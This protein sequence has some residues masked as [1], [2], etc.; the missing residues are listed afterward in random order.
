MQFLA[1]L[2]SC[3]ITDHIFESERRMAEN[4]ELILKSLTE[5]QDT[6][7]K[8][9]ICYEDQY[10]DVKKKKGQFN[11]FKETVTENRRKILAM[12]FSPNHTSF[13]EIGASAGVSKQAVSQF[14]SQLIEKGFI[15]QTKQDG[16]TVYIDKFGFVER[17]LNEE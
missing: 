13:T 3:K 7:N 6:L 14:V 2:V 16:K 4:D 12:L 1:E 5:I 9:F 15:D 10:N 11:S 17:I 8:I